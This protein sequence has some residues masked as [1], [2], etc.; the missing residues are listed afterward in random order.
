MNRPDA[1]AIFPAD[2]LSIS[3]RLTEPEEMLLRVTRVAEI[4]IQAH[5]KTSTH[6]VNK[7]TLDHDTTENCAQ[8]HS[9]DNS[10]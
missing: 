4:L 2:S 10:L 5:V 3:T 9:A 1:S 8:K 7:S 6:N